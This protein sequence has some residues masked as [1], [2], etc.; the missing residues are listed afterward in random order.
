MDIYHLGTECNIVDLKSNI[1][2]VVFSLYLTFDRVFHT[3]EV[4]VRLLS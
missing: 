3:T 1:G 4:Q 2:L